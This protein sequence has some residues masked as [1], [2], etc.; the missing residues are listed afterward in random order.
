LQKP[1]KLACARRLFSAAD[2]SGFNDFTSGRAKI[3][4]APSGKSVASVGASCRC[5]R[6]V[7]HVTKR[8]GGMRWT[9]V[10]RCD[11]RLLSRTAKSCGPGAPT[12]A[13]SWR[14]CSRIAP[15]TVA[16]EPG[17]RGEHEVSRKP[18]RRE[19]RRCSGSP[20]VLPPCFLFARGSWV[21]SAP[22]LPCALVSRKS[23]RMCERAGCIRTARCWN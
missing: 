21:Q 23:V 11:E 20:V 17:H 4:L 19:G 18:P 10:R 9:R 6:G 8:C 22:G 16:K 14:R 3:L 15:T 7:A 5:K 2:S 12:L 13:S 1:P